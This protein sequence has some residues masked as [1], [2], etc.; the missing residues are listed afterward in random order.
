MSLDSDTVRKIAVLARIKIDDEKL[1]PLAEELN[2]I[3]GWVEQLSEVDTDGV[4]P[5]TSVAEMTMP[6]RDD[7]IT[8]GGYEDRVLA[9][10]PEKSPPYFAVPKVVE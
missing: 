2:N 4:A 9:N 8:D 1:P 7:V 10:A 3:I 5:M 6:S